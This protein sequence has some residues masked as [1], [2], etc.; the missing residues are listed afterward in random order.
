[1]RI[2]KVW[3][4]NE[5]DVREKGRNYEVQPCRRKEIDDVN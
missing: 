5:L 3:N 4:K 2:H 1:M